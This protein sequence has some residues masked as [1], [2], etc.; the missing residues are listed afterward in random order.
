MGITDVLKSM[1]VRVNQTMKVSPRLGDQTLKLISL[2]VGC[3]PDFRRR[4]FY[5]DTDC[6]ALGVKKQISA[7]EIR[8]A[9]G[10]EGG[11]YWSQPVVVQIESGV[12]ECNIHPPPG[13]NIYVH[14]EGG[15]WLGTELVQCVPTPVRFVNETT[16]PSKKRKFTGS[17]KLRM[18]FYQRETDTWIASRYILKTAGT[19]A[20]AP[21]HWTIP[22]T[23]PPPVWCCTQPTIPAPSKLQYFPPTTTSTSTSATAYSNACTAITS[24]PNTNSSVWIPADPP[25]LLVDETNGVPIF[26][27]NKE[28][29]KRI[30][31]SIS[32]WMFDVDEETVWRI[33]SQAISR[34]PNH[35]YIVMFRYLPGATSWGPLMTIY[36]R[37]Q[38]RSDFKLEFVAAD[39]PTT[40]ES[41]IQWW[42]LHYNVLTEMVHSSPDLYDLSSHLWNS[43]PNLWLCVPACDQFEELCRGCCLY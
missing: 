19:P 2:P 43:F 12:F 23:L 33:L 36:D 21:D 11:C 10:V 24:A 18:M 27:V 39:I 1:C 37:F 13:V 38:G 32:A 5:E 29:A 35:H 30:L 41:R 34:L 9:P 26:I 3:V 20:T 25:T 6:A 8:Q 16:N 14:L 28:P 17:L 22:L 40:T 31:G 4:A 42:S 15:F 7:L